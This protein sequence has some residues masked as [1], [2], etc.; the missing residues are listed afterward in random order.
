MRGVWEGL[1]GGSGREKYCNYILISKTLKM[2]L[3]DFMEGFLVKLFLHILPDKSGRLTTLSH[4]SL[5]AL[6]V[7]LHV[8][9][10]L[11]HVCTEIR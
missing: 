5:L 2:I 3:H 6:Y 9:Y 11:R 1:E 4:M 7:G 10:T 8:M